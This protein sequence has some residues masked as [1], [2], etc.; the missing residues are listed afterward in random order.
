M[1]RSIWEKA[2][3]VPKRKGGECIRR[4][5]V[6]GFCLA[7]FCICIY[8]NRNN[9]KKQNKNTVTMDEVKDEVSFTNF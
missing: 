7:F 5:W 9:K 8:K 2:S 6:W 4:V 3:L 1:I